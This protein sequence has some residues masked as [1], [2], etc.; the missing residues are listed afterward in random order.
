MADNREADSTGLLY[1]SDPQPVVLQ[2]LRN[3][4]SQHAAAR[5]DHCIKGGHTVQGG[6]YDLGGGYWPNSKGGDTQGRHEACADPIPR[7]HPV[8]ST[9]K[10]RPSPGR[11]RLIH[12]QSSSRRPQRY[13][14]TQTALTGG[15]PSSQPSLTSAA[16]AVSFPNE[17][18]PG[19]NRDR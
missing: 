5:R 10:Y 16:G 18:K 8:T 14:L 3:Y 12:L 6:S 9:R 17:E 13:P 19:G 11:C 15:S 1:S 7:S 4:N 2:L